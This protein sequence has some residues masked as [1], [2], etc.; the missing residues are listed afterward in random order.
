MMVITGPLS[1]RP[2]AWTDVPESAPV[3]VTAV[4]LNCYVVLL[5]PG[6]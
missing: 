2:V 6:P 1:G 3:A 4:R 5:A